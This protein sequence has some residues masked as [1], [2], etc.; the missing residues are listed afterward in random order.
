MPHCDPAAESADPATTFAWTSD[1]QRRWI[2]AE[3]D[4]RS[5]NPISATNPIYVNWE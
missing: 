3:L 1:G 4:R 2:R 5:L